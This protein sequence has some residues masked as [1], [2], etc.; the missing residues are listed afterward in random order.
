MPS[1]D[2]GSPNQ[3][4]ADIKANPQPQT[5]INIKDSQEVFF[6]IRRET[7]LKKL[8]DAYHERTG[9]TTGTVR[10]LVDGE[11]VKPD[12]TPNSL[13]MEDGDQIEVMIEQ[14]GGQ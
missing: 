10:F 14:V 13:D 1:S 7:P 8:M 2:A 3:H 5:H 12:D 11:R 9:R 6:K 4:H